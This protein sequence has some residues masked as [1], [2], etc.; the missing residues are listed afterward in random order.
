MPIARA[1]AFSIAAL[2][3]AALVTLPP[4]PPLWADEAEDAAEE[5]ARLKTQLEHFIKTGRCVNCNLT[6][7]VIGAGK[8]SGAR[9]TNGR[10]LPAVTKITWR[11][12]WNGLGLPPSQ[13]ASVLTASATAPGLGFQARNLPASIYWADG[14]AGSS[15]QDLRFRGVPVDRV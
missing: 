6:G 1:A 14:I 3:C 9:L 11:N 10:T 7:A 5:A 8:L 4:A 12:D 13:I 2:L 15:D